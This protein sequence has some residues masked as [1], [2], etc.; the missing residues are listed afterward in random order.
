MTIL[1]IVTQILIDVN[2]SPIHIPNEDVRNRVN[3]VILPH[4][5]LLSDAIKRKLK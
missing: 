5:N 3:A 2:N 4:D 1:N